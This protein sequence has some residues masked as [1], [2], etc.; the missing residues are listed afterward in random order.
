M[1]LTAEYYSDFKTKNPYLAAKLITIFIEHPVIFIVYSI[2]DPHISDLIFS[3]ASCL[4]DDKLNKFSENLIFLQRS[5]GEEPSQEKVNFNRGGK[6]ISATLIKTDNFSDV[7]R[8]IS[9]VKRKIPARILRYCKEQMFELVRSA[10][11]EQKMAVLDIEDIDEKEDIEFVVGV[12]VA[13]RVDALEK[14]EN[15]ADIG[16]SGYVGLER[17]DLFRNLVFGANDLDAEQVLRSTLAKACRGNSTFNPIYK[18]LSEIGIDSEAELEKSDYESAKIVFSR[19]KGKS[20][21]PNHE[22]SSTFLRLHSGKTGQEIL[23]SVGYQKAAIFLSLLDHDKMDLDWLQGYL[24][25]HFEMEFSDPYSTAFNKLMC[26]YDKLRYVFPEI[27]GT[28]NDEVIKAILGN[29]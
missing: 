29:A 26:L 24:Q 5:K 10:S 6:S 7:Y 17:R 9:R 19:M 15:D 28:T 21:R 20:L 13:S 16:A 2:N 8:C 4:G 12:G 27:Q 1:V 11:P 18:Y 25:D 23:E 14:S 22:Y 3:I